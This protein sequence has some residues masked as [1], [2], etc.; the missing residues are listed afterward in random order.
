MPSLGA[1]ITLAR[2][3]NCGRFA[4][5]ELDMPEERQQRRTDP[6]DGDPGCHPVWLCGSEQEGDGARPSVAGVAAFE[7]SFD[8]AVARYRS[9]SPPAPAS[10]A[11]ARRHGALL[12]SCRPEVSA[13]RIRS[14]DILRTWEE[15]AALARLRTRALG[16]T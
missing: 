10:P 9:G 4:R 6:G 13:S 2:T 8:D 3:L 15:K 14:L 11:T 16:P 12:P 1:I 5:C 7:I